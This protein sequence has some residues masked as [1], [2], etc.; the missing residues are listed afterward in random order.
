MSHFTEFSTCICID[1]NISKNK[2]RC[3]TITG[4]QKKNLECILGALS[5]G[6]EQRLKAST[7]TNPCK[8]NVLRDPNPNYRDDV[9]ISSFCITD[10]R[11][12]RK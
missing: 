8:A 12:I 9:E 6:K 3:N 11:Q 5:K 1:G 10:V 2:T 7:T 4:K